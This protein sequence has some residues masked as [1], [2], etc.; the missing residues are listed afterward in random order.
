MEFNKTQI[1][2]VRNFLTAI[3]HNHR[4]Y[5]FG[6]YNDDLKIQMNSCIMY[7]IQTEKWNE[8]DSMKTARSFASSCKINDN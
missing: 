8:I 5:I 4:L 7:D 2:G 6:G 3:H 1:P